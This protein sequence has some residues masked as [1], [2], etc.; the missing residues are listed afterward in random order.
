MLLQA[1]VLLPLAAGA[2][3]FL[4][5]PDA[6]RRL[7]LLAAALAH[8]GLTA[9]CWASPVAPAWGGT[10]GLDAAGKLFLTI[11][12]V[13]FAAASAYAQSYLRAEDKGLRSDFQEGLAF[14]NAPER[15]FTACLLFF[16]A[17]MTLVAAARHLGLLWVGVEAT[18][19][20]SA[21]LIYFHR[22]R[23]SLEAAWK[24]LIICSVGIALALLG[25]ILLS[26]ALFTPGEGIPGMDLD[27]VLA[28]AASAHPAWLK[29]AFACVLVGYGTK[30]GLAPMHSWLPDAHSESPSLVSALLSGAL[31][32]CALLGVLRLFAVCAVAGL[33]DFA[34]ELLVVFGLASM[35]VATASILGQGDFKRLLAYSSVEHMGVITLGV[36]LGGSAAFGA[37]LHLAGHSLVKAMLFLVAG[38]ILAAFS[39][40]SA[41]DVHGAVRALPVSGPLWVAGFFAIAGCP[42]FSLF[43]SEYTIVTG[44]LAAGRW[45]V[46]AAFLVMLAAVFAG[47]ATPVLRMAQGPT[48]PGVPEGAAE[49]PLSVLPAAALGCGALLLGLW[50]PAPLAEAMRMAAQSFGGAL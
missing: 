4:L 28:R 8:L 30:A 19:L 7:L 43:V 5:R 12:S 9:A 18:T 24:Y 37:M 31:L 27:A 29:A 35:G 11:A 42:P 32:N 40:K 3:A 45:G 16:L 6:P 39:T 10:L 41:H 33:G 36:G 15:V 21:P 25:N 13:L 20:A 44:A 49:A 23:R 2:A 34:R 14:A 38:N 17:A 22:H 26:Y 50:L 46:A 47:M 48:P 1:L